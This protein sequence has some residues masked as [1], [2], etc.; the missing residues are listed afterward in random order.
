MS[1]DEFNAKYN[2]LAQILCTQYNWKYDRENGIISVPFQ[3]L[4]DCNNLEE[5][6]S[7]YM[8]CDDEGYVAMNYS[9][10]DLEELYANM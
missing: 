5:A 8:S 7:Y 4:G 10:D 2:M 6:K 9:L 1:K 3:S